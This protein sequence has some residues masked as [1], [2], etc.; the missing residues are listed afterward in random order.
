MSSWGLANNGKEATECHEPDLSRFYNEADVREDAILFP[1]QAA[2]G[3]VDGLFRGHETAMQ[4]FM[5]KGP[6][7]E[8]FIYDLDTDEEHDMSDAE[9]EY[10]SKDGSQDD[11]SGE[12]KEKRLMKGIARSQES[13]ISFSDDSDDEVSSSESQVTG[14]TS[15]TEDEKQDFA[16]IRGWESPVSQI[17]DVGKSF[18]TFLDRE[19]SKGESSHENRKGLS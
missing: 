14:L 18:Y 2:S 4:E 16:L 19:K 7:W 9:T 10:T 6:N 17:E 12:E 8:R 1:E 5:T 13:K 3:T 15:L 11:G